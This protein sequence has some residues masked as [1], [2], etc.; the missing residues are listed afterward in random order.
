MFEF[1]LSISGLTRKDHVYNGHCSV[2]TKYKMYWWIITSKH[3]LTR[4]YMLFYLYLREEGSI[5]NTIPACL[6][7]LIIM[8]VFLKEKRKYVCTYGNP[9]NSDIIDSLLVK[10]NRN[11]Q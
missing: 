5:T 9:Y 2:M 6:F 7:E 10:C 4:S 1:V 11:L 8:F 3:H